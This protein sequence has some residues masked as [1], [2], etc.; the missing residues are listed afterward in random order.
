MYDDNDDEEEDSEEIRFSLKECVRLVEFNRSYK[1]DDSWIL[2]YENIICSH[3]KIDSMNFCEFCNEHVT[4]HSN[5]SYAGLSSEHKSALIGTDYA[6]RQ[7]N[8]AV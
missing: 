5:L 3:Q 8:L 2:K 6:I 4:N 7:K 1:D